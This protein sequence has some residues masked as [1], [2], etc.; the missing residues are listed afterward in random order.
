MKQGEIG[1]YIEKTPSGE[2]GKGRKTSGNDMSG[3][4]EKGKSSGKKSQSI[5]QKKGGDH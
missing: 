1:A 4:G 5:S 2:V 3:R